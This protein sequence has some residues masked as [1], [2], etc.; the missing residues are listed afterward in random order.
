MQRSRTKRRGA[1][2]GLPGEAVAQ[3]GL[4]VTPRSIW[5]ARFECIRQTP[6]ETNGIVS[7]LDRAGQNQPLE[8]ATEPLLRATGQGTEIH[9]EDPRERLRFR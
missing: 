1:H 8:R 2:C 9:M 5:Q 6:Q 3:A 7:A 4:R